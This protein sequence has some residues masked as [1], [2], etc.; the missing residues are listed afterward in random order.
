MNTTS[1]VPHVTCILWAVERNSNLCVYSYVI[2]KFPCHH[3]YYLNTL[4]KNKKIGRVGKGEKMGAE[5]VDSDTKEQL[6]K[7]GQEEQVRNPGRLP[8]GR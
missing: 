3:I 5:L 4:N 7:S 2:K 1:P 8:G 6:Q